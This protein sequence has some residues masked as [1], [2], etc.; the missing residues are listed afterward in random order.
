MGSKFSF[1]LPWILRILITNRVDEE[2]NKSGIITQENGTRR[3]SGY[4]TTVKSR[5][6][7]LKQDK[8][9]QDSKETIQYFEIPVI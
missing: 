6:N 5:M 1:S 3:E 2:K 7:L 4:S 8:P 9:L